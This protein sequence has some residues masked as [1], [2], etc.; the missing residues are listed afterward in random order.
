ML[1]GFQTYDA[2]AVTSRRQRLA[3]EALLR[4]DGV[5]PLNVQFRDGAASAFPGIETAAVLVGDSLSATGARVRR[6]PLAREMFDVLATRAAGG[7]HRYFAFI[8]ADIV[9]TSSAVREIE[10]Q[11]RESYVISRSDVDD[12]A[13]GTPGGPPMTAGLDMFVVSVSWWQAHRRRFREYVIGETCWDC[14]Y[15]AMLMCH[16]SGVVLNRDVLILHERHAPMWHE[17]TPAAR[18]NGMLAALDAR[19]FSIWAQYWMRLEQVR[20]A[21]TPGIKIAEEDALQRDAFV[22]RPSAYEAARQVVRSARAK[23][24]YQRLRSEWVR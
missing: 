10:R 12:L 14:V 13:S 11:A 9:V 2:D 24:G 6:K 3:G 5:T 19:Y 22:W 15:T 20:A 1:I 8:N 23:R 17:L 4:L 21:G 7:G 16:S 18:Y